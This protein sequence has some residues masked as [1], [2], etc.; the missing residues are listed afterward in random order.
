MDGRE[1]SHINATPRG[2]RRPG[3]TDADGASIDL[4][5]AF[6]TVLPGLHA[7][8]IAPC[9]NTSRNS[10][11]LM[12]VAGCGY[13]HLNATIG[14]T[15]GAELRCRTTR[16]AA[17]RSQHLGCHRTSPFAHGAGQR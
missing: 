14:S 2:R 1:A 11:D 3:L 15:G 9:Q 7:A 16:P 13:S 5:A 17:D 12:R 4:Q 10:P 6:V 8:A